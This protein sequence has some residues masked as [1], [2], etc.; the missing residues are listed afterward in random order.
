MM[1]QN[2]CDHNRSIIWPL[3]NPDINDKFK[4]IQCLFSKNAHF[5]PNTL[6][7]GALQL[8]KWN[9]LTPFLNILREVRTSFCVIVDFWVDS[10]RLFVCTEIQRIYC[11]Q[12][13]FLKITIMIHV[14]G[15][16]GGG[17]L[18]V[19]DEFFAFT[20]VLNWVGAWPH[21]ERRGATTFL[22]LIFSSQVLK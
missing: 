8:R 12:I 17:G 18:W 21:M 19:H 11:I 5:R 22:V 7:H 2:Q 3:A 10:L 4:N 13:L 1:L 15:W 6:L 9:Y 14:F 16:G 20:I